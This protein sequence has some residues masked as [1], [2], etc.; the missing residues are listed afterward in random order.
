VD[1]SLSGSC[2]QC[3]WSW[4]S[5]MTL[6]STHAGAAAGRNWI[7]PVL[8]ILYLQPGARPLACDHPYSK[9]VTAIEADVEQSC[10]AIAAQACRHCT[11]IRHVQPP[12]LTNGCIV[13]VKDAA[14]CR[15]SASFQML[16]ASVASV[17]T[18]ALQR[19]DVVVL[20]SIQPW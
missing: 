19:E 12:S 17:H 5:W 1:G 18:P 13:D 4:G 10:A 20:Q 9:A 15:E 6:W 8:V 2:L 16:H 14:W 3:A 7:C 11:G